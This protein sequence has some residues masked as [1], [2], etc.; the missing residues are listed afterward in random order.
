MSPLTSPALARARITPRWATRANGSKAPAPPSVWRDLIEQGVTEGQRN[1]TITR[2]AGH[3][4]RRRIDP[5]VTLGL[6]RA[7]NA[8]SCRPPLPDEDITRIVNS[9]A[10]KELRRQNG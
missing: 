9:I 6:L 3:L 2:V 10:G 1:T 8:T 5:V 4:L 7:W